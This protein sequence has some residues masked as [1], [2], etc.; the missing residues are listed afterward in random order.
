[1]VKRVAAVGPLSLSIAAGRLLG[2]GLD[3]PLSP[4]QEKRLGPAFALPRLSIFLLGDNPPES[5]DSRDYGAVSIEAVSGRV[6]LFGSRV[7]S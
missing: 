1:V 4:D 3:A 5:L 7:R 2:P 6:L